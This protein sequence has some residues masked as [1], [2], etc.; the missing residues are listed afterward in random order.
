MPC[1]RRAKPA[2][3]RSLAVVGVGREL[4]EERF[5]GDGLTFASSRTS[6]SAP[7]TRSAARARRS[8][9]TAATYL[10]SAATRRSSVPRRCKRLYDH[11]VKSGRGGDD[12]YEH[13]RQSD[14][15]RPHHPR[16]AGDQPH[17]RGAGRQRRSRRPSGRSTPARTALA[18][19]TSTRCSTSCPTDNAQG[20]FL[21]TDAVALLIKRGKKV[22]ALVCARRRGGARRQLPRAARRGRA[23]RCAMRVLEQPDGLRRDRRRP[24]TRRLST[25]ARRIGRDTAIK[26]FVVIEGPSQNWRALRQSG[27]LR[28]FAAPR[29]SATESRSAISWRSDRSSVGEGS[30]AKHLAFR[31]R[32]EGRRERQHRR[33]RH[34]RQLE[35]QGT[36]HVTEIGDGA[37]IGAGTV[38]VAP[39]EDR[40]QAARPAQAR[41][42]RRTGPSRPARCGSACRRTNWGQKA[43]RAELIMDRMKVFS[44]RRLARPRDG[45]LRL[46]RRAAGQGGHRELP[47]RRDSRQGDRRRARQ[48]RLHRAVDLH[49]GQRASD[50]AP[51]PHRLVKRASAASITAVIPYYGYA[52]QDSKDEGRVPITARLVADMIQA[53]GANRVLTIDLHASQIQGFFDIPRRPSLRDAGHG[54]LL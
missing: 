34:H 25:S 47:G 45:Y 18:G 37:Q 19:R 32:R 3:A 20:E 12:S 1:A 10:S 49:A 17:R 6:S 40:G 7:A 50:G 5:E 4:V 2:R 27:R 35:R 26:P 22:E 39:D 11:T 48:R 31:G 41:L 42:L 24:A 53:A 51:Y 13:R 28:I 33:G 21:L 8:T 54:A 43:K 46:S 9:A 15:L 38:L 23:R 29:T 36:S 30:R 14:R 44:G 52:R 16:D